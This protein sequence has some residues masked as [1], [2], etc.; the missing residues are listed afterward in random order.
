MKKK[1]LI[2]SLYSLLLDQ[3]I[4]YIVYKSQINVKLIPNFLSLTYTSN[5][6]IAFSLLSGS[7]LIII[8]SSLILVVVLFY[9]LKNDY[10]SKGRDNNLLDIAYGVLFGGIL[11]NLIDRVIRGYVIDYVS[12]KIFNYY[13]PIFNLADVFI[14][15]GV[16][17]LLCVKF[18]DD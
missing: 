12:I 9:L 5:N 15:I 8:L 13:F 16:V 1:I 14:T 7:R 3:V 10:L 2:Y 11:G 6:G 4:K 17:L 18:E